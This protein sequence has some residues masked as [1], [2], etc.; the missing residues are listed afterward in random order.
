LLN[1]PQQRILIIGASRGLGRS[2]ALTLAE[3]H[4]E[5]QILLASRKL[6]ELNKVAESCQSKSSFKVGVQVFDCSTT[7]SPAEILSFCQEQAITCVWYIAGG[8]PYGLY[9]EKKWKSHEWSFNLNF[10]TPA[11]IIY[12]FL[13]EPS[14][15]SQL[16][17]IG[18]SIAES[19]PDPGAASYA[20]SKHALKG[21]ISTIQAE[22]KEF[23]LRLYSPGY[24][25]TSMLP[26]NAPPVVSG[27]A[28]A[29][30]I[31]AQDFVKWALQP[32]QKCSH[33]VALS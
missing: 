13:K 16:I 2:I 12:D 10:L 22:Q 6:A 9:S 20:A 4:P 32:D 19:M 33:Y 17:F 8:G 5:V 25:R 24:I 28:R 3:Q 11:R 23:D 26:E 15:V 1:L 29:P 18:S 31:V 7:Q 21:L 27:L 14:A 30:E